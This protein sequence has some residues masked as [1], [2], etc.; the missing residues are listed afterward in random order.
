MKTS[1]EA[2]PKTWLAQKATSHPSLAAKE[3]R[4]Y[5]SWKP[6][7]RRSED[8]DAP[9][10]ITHQVKSLPQFIGLILLLCFMLQG[11][12]SWFTSRES[13]NRVWD[14]FSYKPVSAQQLAL[15]PTELQE[16]KATCATISHQEHSSYYMGAR[17]YDPVEGRFISADPLGHG[18]SMSLYDYCNGDPVN[19]LDPDGRCKQGYSAGWSNGDGSFAGT[20]DPSQ[21]SSEVGYGAG[22]LVGGALGDVNAMFAKPIGLAGATIAGVGLWGVNSAIEAVNEQLGGD[23]PLGAFGFMATAPLAAIEAIGEI[24]AAAEEGRT[25][26]QFPQGSFS[27]TEYGWQGYPAGIPKPAG[28]FRLIEGEEYN[29]ARSTANIS[30]NQIRVQQGL[31]GQPVDVH[32]IHPVKFGGSATDPA[33]KIPLDRT[34]HRQQVTPWWNKLMRIISGG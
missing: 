2:P 29:E 22:W 14:F 19:G 15:Q 23:N 20:Y 32:E 27:I 12:A 7:Q 30:N 33:N 24:S 13:E 25:I 28:P 1:L 31:Q 16:T 3:K 18:A 11:P 34:I 26:A 6:I 9:H 8:F 5:T 21:S 17:Y 10:Q 4:S